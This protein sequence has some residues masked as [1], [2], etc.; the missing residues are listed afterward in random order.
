M[1]KISIDNLIE[2]R[3]KTS[4]STRFTVLN[5]TQKEIVKKPDGTGGNYWVSCLSTIAK[6]FNTDDKNLIDEKIED[7]RNR[8]ELTEHRGTKTRWQK[9][10]DILFNFEDFDFNSI[11]PSGALKFLKKSDDKSVIKINDL[12]IEAK[13]HHVFSYSNNGFEEIGAIWFIAKKEGF[14]KSE[15]GMFCDIIHRYLIINFSDNYKINPR[16]CIA[17]DLF[18]CQDVK[19]S[20]LLEGEITYLLDSTIDEVKITLSKLNYN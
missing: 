17:V 1:K 9:N 5:N 14:K 13:P 2:F 4:D 8:I 6:I 16:Y 11:K 20:Q 19:Y 3:R 15:L 18:N 12:L 10:I 7:L